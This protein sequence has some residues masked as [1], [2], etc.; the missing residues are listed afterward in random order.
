MT[1]KFLVCPPD[2]I[3][4][5]AHEVTPAQLSVMIADKLGIQP[6]VGKASEV[7]PPRM[8]SP[9]GEVVLDYSS[10]NGRLCNRLR[11]AGIRN[12]VVECERHQYS[13]V[14]RPPSINGVALARGS[15][16]ISQV[17]SAALLDYTSRTRTP[18]R[19]QIVVLRNTEG[20][21]AA[22]QLLE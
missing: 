2:I 10:Y 4:V 11:S 20:F 19:G 15:E 9:T 6:F 17:E 5:R 12:E 21:Y 22:V 13:R 3:Y 18:S 14:Q 8:T 16:S 1:R 7:P